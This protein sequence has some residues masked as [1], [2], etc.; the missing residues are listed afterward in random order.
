MPMP[1][2][3]MGWGFAKVK[4]MRHAQGS[5]TL[6]ILVHEIYGLNSHIRQA[7]EEL[8]TCGL[9]VLAPNLLQRAEPFSYGEAAA[10]YEHFNRQVGFAQAAETI[11]ALAAQERSNYR[12][13]VLLGYSVGATVAWLCSG[14]GQWDGVIGCYGSRIRDYQTLQP[15]CPV[16]LFFALD[17]PSFDVMPLATLLGEKQGVQVEVLAAQHGFMDPFAKAYEPLA[18]AQV[19]KKIREFIRHENE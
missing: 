12:R 11:Q 18:A 15:A 7:A 16:R 19:E 9:D 5:N 10:A 2:G 8:A 17:E 1:T 13:I 4:M 6:V 3:F 14:R